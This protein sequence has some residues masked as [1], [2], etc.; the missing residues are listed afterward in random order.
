MKF[1]EYE[2]NASD[3]LEAYEIERAKI[4]IKF[5]P[6]YVVFVNRLHGGDYREK[7]VVI[8]DAK[9][10]CE[11]NLVHGFFCHDAATWWFEDL[12]EA[13]IFKLTWC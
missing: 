5:K 8:K 12:K 11:E 9:A 6:A 13:M 3:A 1:E 4:F 7:V 10:W 2:L